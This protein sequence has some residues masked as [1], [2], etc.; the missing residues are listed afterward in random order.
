MFKRNK[1]QEKS[2]SVL[3][4]KIVISCC[5]VCGRVKHTDILD[6]CS[7][8]ILLLSLCHIILSYNYTEER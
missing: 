3:S 8:C 5:F 2:L 1:F 6:N 4:K 7:V